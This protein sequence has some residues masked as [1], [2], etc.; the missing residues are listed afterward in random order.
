MSDYLSRLSCERIRSAVDHDLDH[1]KTVIAT[2]AAVTAERLFES[3]CEM[4]NRET[5]G[6]RE[7][8]IGCFWDRAG[9]ARS[10]P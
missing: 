8:E 6:W 2:Y 1:I 3:G 9:P 4:V 5:T 10:S 7:E